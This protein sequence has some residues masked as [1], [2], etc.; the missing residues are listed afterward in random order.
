M[1][2]QVAHS[3]EKHEQFMHAIEKQNNEYT[4]GYCAGFAQF[5]TSKNFKQVFKV[6]L[7]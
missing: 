7:C 5:K 2:L 1:R 3:Q 4:T 6:Q